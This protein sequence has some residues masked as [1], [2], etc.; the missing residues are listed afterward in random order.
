MAVAT[1]TSSSDNIAPPSQSM[2]KSPTADATAA[3]NESPSAVHGSSSAVTADPVD[4]SSSSPKPNRLLEFQVRL[5]VNT[6][7]LG[8]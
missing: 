8:D 7:C 6:T 2:D 3:A 4:N 1:T 5:I